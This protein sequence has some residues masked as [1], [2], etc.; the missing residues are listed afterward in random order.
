VKGGWLMGGEHEGWLGGAD[1]REVK[2]GGGWSVQGERGGK[3][4]VPGGGPRG[5]EVA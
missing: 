5:V 1:Y 2:T 3:R 4:T